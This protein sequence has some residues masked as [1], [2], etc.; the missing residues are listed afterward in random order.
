[1]TTRLKIAMGL[2]HAQRGSVRV[3][4]RDPWQEPV[5]VKR[6]IGYVSEDQSLPTF[7]PVCDVLAL[8]RELFP[9]WDDAL[10]REFLDRFGLDPGVRIATLSKGQARQVAF[11]C[12]IA[13][14]PELLILDEPA[15]GLDPAA[16]REVPQAP[17]P[18]LHHAGVTILFSSHHMTDLERLA[19]RI[20]FIH[21]GRKLLDREV[22]ALREGF[23]LV[24][25][26]K[27]ADP[28]RARALPG[29]V[30]FRARPDGGHAVF[31]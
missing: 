15:G 10:T 22:D 18:R 3:F 16:R 27:T 12:A 26:P 9:T 23:F 29:F 14:H 28:E 7:L 4:D 11:L 13:H 1:K 20:V 25:L 2:L 30:A 31:E 21:G 5:E 8:H 24:V 19:G 6:R 17:I